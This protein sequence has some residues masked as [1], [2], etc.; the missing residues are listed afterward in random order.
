[1]LNDFQPVATGN[2]HDQKPL[3]TIIISMQI[4]IS[5]HWGKRWNSVNTHPKGAIRV[6]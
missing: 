2:H 6:D 1:M 3:E 4:R 5:G